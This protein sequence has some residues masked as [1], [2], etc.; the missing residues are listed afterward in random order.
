M[1]EEKGISPIY[2]GGNQLTW[3]LDDDHGLWN[4]VFLGFTNAAVMPK[5]E[6]ERRRRPTTLLVHPQVLCGPGVM[7][8]L[9]RANHA[10][11]QRYSVRQAVDEMDWDIFEQVLTQTHNWEDFQMRPRIHRVFNYEALIPSRVPPECISMPD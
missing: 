1:M 4:Y 6:N 5:Y 9:G 7:I 8:A 2:P 10:Y 11:T 3:T